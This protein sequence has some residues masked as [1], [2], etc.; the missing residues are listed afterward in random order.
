MLDS[1]EI[2]KRQDINEKWVKYLCQTKNK[3]INYERVDS[4]KK[5]TNKNTYNYVMR[6]LEILDS[7]KN[8]YDREVIYYVE[9]TLKWSEIAKGGTKEDIKKWK[10]N[11][12]NLY[13]HNI[14]SSEIYVMDNKKYNNVIRVL[15]K[16]HGLIGQYLRGEINF[17]N[18]EELYELIINNEIDKN[19]LKHVLI[20]LNK[21]VVGAVSLSLYNKLEKRILECIEDIINGNFN[22][23][24]NIIE[25]LS[26]LNSNLSNEEKEVL[27]NILSNS[28][29]KE[30]IENIF[31]KLEFWFYEAA[32]NEFS[33][34]EQIK[35]LLLIYNEIGD[36]I[37]Y[38]TFENLMKM[39]YFDYEG[40]RVINI[41]KKRIIENFI[42]SFDYNNIMDNNIPMN[43]HISF[44]CLIRHDT[45]IP[46]FKF[47]KP[48]SKL[49]EF[50]EVAYISDSMYNKAVF[51]LYDLF[52][53][54]RDT[55][56]RF[57]NE[58]SYLNTMNKSINHKAI[59][60]NYLVGTD[61]LDVGP[62][63]GALMD[64]I[65]NNNDK[66]NVMGIDISSNV[67][68]TLKS[69]YECL[70]KK[71]RIII[72]DGIKTEPEDLYRIIEFKNN[73]DIEI[74][75]RYCNDFKGRKI[76]YEKISDNRVK[77][78]VNDAMEFLYTYTWGENSYALEVQE[79][80]GYYTPS[81]YI[82]VIKDNLEG[83]NIIVCNAFLQD[84]YE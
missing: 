61:I 75:N 10:K 63:G 52:G 64:L 57:Y 70:R 26:S 71:G 29:I 49:I 14:G 53:F 54:R 80:F 51:M 19:T 15:I 69:A 20:L 24:M 41:Y 83:A 31:D 34:E 3:F 77:M 1:I 21:C 65:L 50:C 5:I 27:K 72:R 84:G 55:Y 37:K 9:E 39:I 43:P 22:K 42:S 7:E 46:M 58:I 60:L 40:K 13:V 23:E 4:L 11:N 79:Q 81:E 8:N 67:I 6:T 56:D 33:I 82:K 35:I 12:F 48:A 36:N 62:G 25:K 59:I 30:K 66:L 28:L 74:L 18:N 68:A 47:S 16:T 44:K 76:T 32:M 38:I 78:L 17:S 2:L 73:S 45:I